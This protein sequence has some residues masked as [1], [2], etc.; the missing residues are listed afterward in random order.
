MQDDDPGSKQSWQDWDERQLI[1]PLTVSLSLLIHFGQ[2]LTPLY[3]P[4]LWAAYQELTA[5]TPSE[6]DI[7]NTAKRLAEQF[8]VSHRELH[9]VWHFVNN[10]PNGDLKRGVYDLVDDHNSSFLKAS[11]R[12]GLQY[13]Q[14]RAAFYSAFI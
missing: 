10:P 12:Y 1:H 6:N 8:H 11:D 2:G 14:L 4:D 7:W 5:L 3:F 13:H 9:L